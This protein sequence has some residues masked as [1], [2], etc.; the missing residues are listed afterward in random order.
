MFLDPKGCRVTYQVVRLI[1][2]AQRIARKC[3]LTLPKKKKIHHHTIQATLVTWMKIHHL[4]SIRRRGRGK[5]EN[6]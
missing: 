4:I 6:A 1:R 5:L 3:P 2:K